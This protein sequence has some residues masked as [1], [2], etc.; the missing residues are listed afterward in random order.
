MSDRDAGQAAE[1]RLALQAIQD[2]QAAL[3][4]DLDAG[5]LLRE[6]VGSKP[7]TATLFAREAGRLAGKAWFEATFAATCAYAAWD[8]SWQTKEGS[9]FSANAV[10][11]KLSGPADSVVAG[12][13]T[14]LNFLQ[15]LSGVA[16]GAAALATAAAPVPV[17]DTRKTLPKLRAAQ[18]YAITAGGMHP[19]RANLHEAAILKDNH[20]RAAGSIAR[21]LELATA[22][23][24]GRP[25]QI[26]VGSTAELDEALA[27]GAKRIMLDNFTVEQA[28]QAVKRCA[29]QAELEASGGIAMHNIAAYA[30]TGVDRISCGDVTKN[31][32]AI[33]LSLS[34]EV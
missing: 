6:V 9:D 5:D 20:I 25:L 15:L 16:T 19:N 7:V 31:V 22:Q 12:E 13:R 23:C 24:R 8:C 30:A 27:A 4:E 26:E 2:V 18:K 14:A 3:A 17:Y 10:L 28:Q 34:F 11:A 21:A 29:G 33:D 32:R 1:K